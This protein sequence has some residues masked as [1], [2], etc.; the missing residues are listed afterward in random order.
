MPYVLL[1]LSFLVA[2]ATPVHAAPLKVMATV[3]ELAAIARQVGGDEVVVSTMAQPGQDPHFVDARPSLALDLH[4]AD[5]LIAVGLDLEIGWL[6]VLQS[7]ARNPRI[8]RGGP[9]WLDA[10]TVIQPLDVAPAGIDRSQ[11]DL[12]PGGNPHYLL[13]PRN[14]ARVAAAISSR[15][16]MLRPERRALF[17]TRLHEFLAEL[18]ARQ[19]VWE[20]RLAP[21]AGKRVL[22]YHRS[23]SYL[24]DWLG[25][26][27][28]GELEPKPGIPPSPAHL[29]SLLLRLEADKPLFL[30]QEPWYPER[31][32]V[33]FSK[34]LGIAHAVLPVGP[35]I[36]EGESWIDWMERVV[37]V[38]AQA[39]GLS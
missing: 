33:M 20:A 2:T 14:V 39:G 35:K 18:S 28:A 32:A 5:L 27:S 31:T 21:L 11:G 29:S 34:R 17:D 16:A 9:G 6:P 37:D 10:S 38:I 12:H 7:G 30:L 25:L 22:S 8:L 1:A 15:L 13:D 36:A 24:F 3:P 4:K 26:R 23:L 19:A